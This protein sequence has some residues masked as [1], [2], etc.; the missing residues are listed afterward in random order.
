MVLGW[1]AHPDYSSAADGAQAGVMTPVSMSGVDRVTWQETAS[2]SPRLPRTT[3]ST[4][5]KGSVFMNNFFSLSLALPLVLSLASG[6]AS[7]KEGSATP[8]PGA[9]TGGSG[10]G[11]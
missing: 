11:G 4:R 7:S 5:A 3:A 9:G 8:G 6:C 1:R 10:D 2:R